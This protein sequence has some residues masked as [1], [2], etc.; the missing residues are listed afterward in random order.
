MDLWPICV[1]YPFPA[2]PVHLP[3]LLTLHTFSLVSP[4]ISV[5]SGSGFAVKLDIALGE[6]VTQWFNNQS[7]ITDAVFFLFFFLLRTKTLQESFSAYMFIPSLTLFLFFCLQ[8]VE[9]NSSVTLYKLGYGLNKEPDVFWADFNCS[10]HAGPF[11]LAG[12]FRIGWAYRLMAV[13]VWK[14]EAAAILRGK[15]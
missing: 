15:L 11:A 8:P 13:S 1:Q 6:N 5:F 2:I 7:K 3:S 9:H 12:C 14:T 4:L 10:C